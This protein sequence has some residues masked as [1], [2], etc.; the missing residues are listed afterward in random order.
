LGG[1]ATGEGGS[2]RTF[3]GI[4]PLAPGLESK[5]RLVQLHKTVFLIAADKA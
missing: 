3:P 5:D 2:S 4:Q 1:L